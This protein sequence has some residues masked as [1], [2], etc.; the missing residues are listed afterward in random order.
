M[1]AKFSDLTDEQKEIAL[2]Q[3]EKS[4]ETILSLKKPENRDFLLI[5]GKV[6]GSRIHHSK[7]VKKLYEIIVGPN[8]RSKTDLQDWKSTPTP[9]GLS[10]D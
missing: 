4:T 7:K 10:R 8:P 2:F 9:F 5:D 3:L 6:K 1:W